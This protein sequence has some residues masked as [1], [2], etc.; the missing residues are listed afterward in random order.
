MDEFELKIMQIERK[1]FCDMSGIGEDLSKEEI[2]RYNELCRL[3]QYY[4]GDMPSHL[5]DEKLVLLDKA[6][7]IKGI[8]FV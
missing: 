5:Y 3:K 4:G 2:D 8:P 6:C 1:I 7:K